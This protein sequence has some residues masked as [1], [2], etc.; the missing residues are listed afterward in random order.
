MNHRSIAAAA[1]LS[2]GATQA[3]AQEAGPTLSYKANEGTS[4]QSADQNYKITLGGRLQAQYE[5]LSADLGSAGGAT[6][7]TSSFRVRR[8]YLTAKGNLISKALTFNITGDWKDPSLVDGWLSYKVMDE[9]QITGGQFVVPFARQEINS[10]AGL[11]LVERSPVVI[12]Y[13]P[14][15]D[16][17]AKVSGKIAGGL[18][19]YDL[20]AFN[21]L[22]ANTRRKTPNTAYAARA[23]VNPLGEL[24]YGEGDI[25][26]NSKPLVA[27]GGSYFMNRVA[28]TS[29]GTPAAAA[30]EANAADYL[31]GFAKPMLLAGS[32]DVVDIGMLG[33]D[34]AG[35]WAGLYV[36]AEYFMGTAT[37]KNLTNAAAGA[38]GAA[39]AKRKLESSGYYA[40][41]GYMVLPQKLEV[42]ARY[43]AYDPNTNSVAKHD[44]KTEIAG[45]LNYYL[46]KHGFKIQ[47]EVASL[48]SEAPKAGS[49]TDFEKRNDLRTRLQAQVLY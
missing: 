28:F 32:A 41:A 3:L 48:G 43:G 12:Y 9:L 23:V 35:K 46:A 33:V 29:S 13:R 15:Y 26:G 40:Q 2:L 47:L 17:G 34:L 38:F 14:S 45:G 16:D 31:A 49:P 37:A 22:G 21:G 11:Q 1:L 7:D 18:L 19:A 10:S 4:I 44:Q 8:A 36:Q 6:K 20:G 39:G 5:Y 42:V 27:L 24:P 25:D 30:Y